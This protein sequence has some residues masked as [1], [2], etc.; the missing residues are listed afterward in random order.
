MFEIGQDVRKQILN[1]LKAFESFF[2]KRKRFIGVK[3]EIKITKYLNK[4][5]RRLEL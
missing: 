1:Q 4:I 5:K 2:N 3:N